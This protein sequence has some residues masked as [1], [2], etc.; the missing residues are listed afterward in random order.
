MTQ[1]HSRCACRMCS[2]P[3]RSPANSLCWAWTNK[4]PAIEERI[5]LTTRCGD[6]Q[7]GFCCTFFFF[8]FLRA[9]GEGEGEGE[10]NQRSIR[11]ES[12]NHHND[13]NN[14]TFTYVYTTENASGE[15]PLHVEYNN[16]KKK[17]NVSRSLKWNVSLFLVIFLLNSP[18]TLKA[19][20]SSWRRRWRR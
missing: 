4:S 7:R 17:R 14:K 18:E 11:I 5:E 6:S 9:V 8:P 15:K 16:R 12:T 3:V 20:S 1:V 2:T 10:E 13:K 19:D